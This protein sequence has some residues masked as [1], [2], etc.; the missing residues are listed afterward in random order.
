MTTAASVGCGRSRSSPGT[1]SSIEVI[2][3]APT[4][5]VTWVFAP[6]CSA[7]AVREPLVLTGK[8]W[9]KPAAMLA[10]PIPIISRLPSTSSPDRSAKA[11]EV[12]IVSASETSAMPNAP[13]ISVGRS[14]Q[15]MSGMVNGGNPCG[16]RAH[17][18]DAMLARGRT[19]RRPRSTPRP[20]PERSARLGSVVRSTTITAEAQHAD[21]QRGGH[22]LAVRDALDERP[23]SRRRSRRHRR[24]SRTASEAA[25]PG[26]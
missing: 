6:A 9:K 26:S 15:L 24:R 10:A 16:K 20:R 18:L 8:P 1:N 14:E 21:R 5:P 7:T 12:A 2:A 13:P 19:R 25:R 11:D 17:Q 3:S 23:R 4:S 22:R